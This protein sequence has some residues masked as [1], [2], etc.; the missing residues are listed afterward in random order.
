MWLAGRRPHPLTRIRST[1]TS[2]RCVRVRAL[3]AV[4][5]TEGCAYLL[6]VGRSASTPTFAGPAPSAM[7]WGGHPTVTSR[8]A[9]RAMSPPAPRAPPPARG[10]RRPPAPPAQPP[11]RRYPHRLRPFTGRSAANPPPSAPPI[12]PDRPGRDPVR[13]STG[14]LACSDRPPARSQGAQPPS[15][16]ATHS[17][18]PPVTPHRRAGRRAPLDGPA[19]QPS[20]RAWRRRL[21]RRRPARLPSRPAPMAQGPPAPHPAPPASSRTPAARESATPRAPACAGFR[22][23]RIDRRA[24]GP[25]SHSDRARAASGRAIPGC[26]QKIPIID[27]FIHTQSTILADWT[28]LSCAF[29]W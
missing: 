17:A 24:R 29:V 14:L 21:V 11:T 27:P 25:G 9:T 23:F 6:Q 1:P 22:I 19:S 20:I 12:R 8:S 7:S 18:Q 13:R 28:L 16:P 5:H 26:P 2:L 15:W 3:A 10:P 4:T